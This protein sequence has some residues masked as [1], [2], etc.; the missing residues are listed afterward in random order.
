VKWNPRLRTIIALDEKTWWIRSFN[1]GIFIFNPQTR[2]F[3][4]H[5]VNDASCR[6]CLPGH[7]NFLLR[8]K[9]QRVFATTNAGL[10]EYDIQRDG[11]DKVKISGGPPPGNTQF[12]LAEDSSGLI[13]IA[14]ENGIFVFNPDSNRIVKTFP[15]NNKIGIVFRICPDDHQNM[16]FSSNSGYWCWLRKPD[17]I[18]HF[19][20]S[21]GLPK[22]E[23]GIFYKTADGSVYGGGRDAVVRFYPDRLMNYT[24][25]AKTKIIEAL[26]N[27]TLVPF[28]TGAPGQKTLALS[29]DENSININFDVVNYDLIRNNQYFYRLN[30]GDKGWEQSENGHLSFYNLQP[31]TYRLEVR[32][33]SKLTGKFTNTDSLDI[34]IRPYWYQSDWFKLILLALTGILIFFIARYRIRMVRKE[35]AFRQ[36]I[37]ETEMTALRTQMNP[38]FIFNSLNSIENFIM[39][40]E[41]RLASDYLN[42]FARLIRMILENSRKQ[43]VPLAKDMEALQLY[44]DLEQLRF[45]NK[46]GYI[47]DIDKILLDG[48]YRVP[49]LLIQPFVENAIV[50]GLAPCDRRDLHLEISIKLCNDYIHYTI[51]DNGIGRLKSRAYGE[52][53]KTGHKSLG[54]QITRERIEILY[55]QQKANGI[56]E[57]VD[58]YDDNQRAAGTRVILTIKT[59]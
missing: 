3:I 39:Q 47:T 33:A 48:D 44:V 12:G 7:I 28:G 8:D 34:L 17:K 10:F 21:Q 1:Q 43:M 36:K 58:L 14:A 57:I 20:Y 29:P 31:G 15:E 50:H 27:D 2:Q 38:H 32:G 42:K 56:L 41:K 22:T 5:Y 49:P 35:A 16:W 25:D 46:F 40:N 6:E 24:V 59:T 45:N 9:K 26:V 13:W 19:E 4:K 30:P 37:I 55:R 52:Q 11:F 18:I 54:L 51:Q 53:N 23:E